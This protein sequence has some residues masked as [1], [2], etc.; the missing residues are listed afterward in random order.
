MEQYVIKGGQP[1]E[2][3]VTIAGAKNAALGILAAAVMT[4]QEVIIE[5]VP[6]VR[7]TRVLLQAIEGIGAKVRYIDEHTV[8][9]C[10]ASINPNSDL[11]VDDEFIRKIRASYYLLGALLGKY[12][13]SQ[14][15]LPGGCDIGA[16]PINLHIKGFE[17]LGAQVD[18]TNGTISTYAEELIGSHIYMDVAS[19]GATI[20]IMMAAVLAEGKTTIENAAKEPHIVD[21]ANFLN[22]MGANIKGAGTDVIRI[23]GVKELHGTTYSIIPDQIEAGTFMVAAAAT[24]GN[25]L[26]KNVIPKH[27]EAITSKLNEIGA[28]VIEY[29]DSVRVMSDKRLKSTNIKTLPYPGFPTDMQPQMAVTLALSNGTSIVT[30]SIFE[31][32][33]KYVAELT[34]MGAHIR[35]E[36]NTAIIDGVESFTGA[37]VAAPDLR[38]GAA[39][40][41]A[42]LVADDFSVVSDIKYIQRGYEKFDEKLQCLGAKIEKVDTEKD[43]QKFKLKIG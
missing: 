38:A 17:E 7:D 5:N 27:L 31:N 28:H 8:S 37:N 34:R 15:A 13:R 43:I 40:V 19:V 30:E 16:R 12:K 33:F 39:L 22:S 36:G 20:N 24:K 9:I 41:I 10:G 29:D 3:E 26:I 4:D 2:G 11:C 1:L 42:A 32:R 6:N 25:V 23:R 18:I 21:V 35:V 14:V